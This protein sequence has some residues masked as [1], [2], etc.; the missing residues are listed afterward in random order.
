M[1]VILI[2]VLFAAALFIGWILFADYKPAELRGVVYDCATDQP[3]AGARVRVP[4][5]STFVDIITFQWGGGE[6]YL[7]TTDSLGRF[8]INYKGGAFNAYV[9]KDQ[10]LDASEFGEA[11]NARIG[12]VAR[13]PADAIS[14]YSRMCKRSSECLKT[15]TIDGVITVS[16]VCGPLS[17]L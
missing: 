2:L 5:P 11:G 1:K 6:N 12:L 4:R 3:I 8:S 7:A 16:D 13:A 9:S 10:Y 14:E 17:S 15:E